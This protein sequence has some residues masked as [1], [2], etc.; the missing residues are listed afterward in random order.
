MNGQQVDVSD[1]GILTTD[2]ILFVSLFVQG[3]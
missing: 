2:D 3:F 1:D